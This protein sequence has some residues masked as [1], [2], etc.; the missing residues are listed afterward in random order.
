MVALFNLSALLK[1]IALWFSSTIA[2]SSCSHAFEAY[3]LRLVTTVHFPPHIYL[4][5]LVECDCV[6]HPTHVILIPSHFGCAMDILSFEFCKFVFMCLFYFFQLLVFLWTVK[7][8]CVCVCLCVFILNDPLA[9]SRTL[10]SPYL[11]KAWNFQP[12]PPV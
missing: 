8:I 3:L 11:A 1:P 9:L 6:A 7:C 2:S 12:I 10:F 5:I 4:P